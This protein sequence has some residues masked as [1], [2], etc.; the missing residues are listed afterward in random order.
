MQG[1][2]RISHQTGTVCLQR[3]PPDACISEQRMPPFDFL[4]CH[5]LEA[6]APDSW[7]DAIK[8]IYTGVELFAS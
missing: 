7:S 5:H 2:D 4:L 6:Q 8:N 3:R 1:S